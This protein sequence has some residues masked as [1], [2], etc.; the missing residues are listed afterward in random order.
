MTAADFI[1]LGALVLFALA[2]IGVTVRSINLTAAGLALLTLYVLLGD[3][4]L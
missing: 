2:A 3:G 4:I 1:L